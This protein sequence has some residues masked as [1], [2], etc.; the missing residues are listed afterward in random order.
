MDSKVITL[1]GMSGVGKSHWS[2]ILGKEGYTVFHIDDLISKELDNI[3]NKES[4]D[5]NVDYGDSEVGTLARWMGFPGDKRY[6][7]NCKIYLKLEEKITLQSLNKALKNTGRSVIDTTGSVIYLNPTLQK[8]LKQNSQIIYLDVLQS[9]LDEMLETF[10]KFPK[11]IIWGG[12]YKALKN[13]PEEKTLV[14]CYK[15]L[16]EF[17]VAKYKKLAHFVIPYNSHKKSK[18]TNF[19]KI[20]TAKSTRG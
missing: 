14:R 15:K 9:K 10:C 6:E 3:I 1:I 7:R 4:G 16:L 11:P 12:I 17:R 13:E 20:K 5:K 18:S 19:I 2:E 8:K